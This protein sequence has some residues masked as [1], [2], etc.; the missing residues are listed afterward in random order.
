M[1][2]LPASWLSIAVSGADLMFQFCL[3]DLNGFIDFRDLHN[4]NL[5]WNQLN[6]VPLLVTDE[7]ILV[8]VLLLTS[9]EV[10]LILLLILVL[11]VSP[12]ADNR[13]CGTEAT[14]S[15]ASSS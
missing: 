10:S 8:P 3:P 6:R 9:D 1:K 4:Q 7:A 11:L 13:L 12:S 15:S 2:Y 5:K 14:N